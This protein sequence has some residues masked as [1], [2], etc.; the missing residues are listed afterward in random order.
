MR[1]PP[2]EFRALDLRAHGLMRDVPLHDVSAVD[3]PG[4]GTGT[5]FITEG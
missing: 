3:L 1:E 4:G 5:S 2:D